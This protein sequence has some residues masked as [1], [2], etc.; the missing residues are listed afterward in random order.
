MWFKKIAI[1]IASDGG[2]ESRSGSNDYDVMLDK[3][4]SEGLIDRS[5]SF[6]IRKEDGELYINGEM[7]S[8]AVYNHYRKYLHGKK[9]IVKG[10]KGDLS[11]SVEN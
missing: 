8:D 5:R 6:K 11:I 2:H 1:A 3:M 10:K 9:V 7:Q 4:D